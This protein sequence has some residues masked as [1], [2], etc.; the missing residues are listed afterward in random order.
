MRLVR[1]PAAERRFARF[2]KGKVFDEAFL[3]PAVYCRFNRH[4]LFADKGV[5][6]ATE[7]KKTSNALFLFFCF[8]IVAGTFVLAQSFLKR[9]AV[10][11]A[12]QPEKSALSVTITDSMA[13]EL[14]RSFLP[15]D[16]PVDNTSLQ[17][18]EKGILISGE[19]D[20]AKII[21]LTIEKS[22]PELAAVRS[23]L[24]VR[25]AFSA[26]FSAAMDDGTLNIA[27]ESFSLGN[28]SIPL[29]LLPKALKSAVGDLLASQIEK[30][31]FSVTDIS[32]HTG[33]MTVHLK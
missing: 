17:F 14:L 20:T 16:F 6:A 3:R 13:N 22:Y 26:A 32:L 10:G 1:A 24:P 5:D 23:L 12:G 15:A 28:Y 25:V 9:K 33:Q 21:D 7:R 2:C 4:I 27:P 31:G 11:N 8:L 30:N 18:V 29:G 19:A